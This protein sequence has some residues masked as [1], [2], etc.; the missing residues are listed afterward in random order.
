MILLVDNFDSFTFNLVDYFEQLGTSVHI[1]RNNVSPDAIDINKFKGIV[2]SPGPGH[3][4]KAGYLMAIIHKFQGSIPMLGIC[5]GHQAIGKYYGAEIIKAVEPMHGKIS[6]I[7]I[8]KD[9]IFRDMPDV[10]KVVRYHSLVLSTIPENLT[11]IAFTSKQE[12]M[13]IKHNKL[14]I[15]GVQFHPEAYLTSYGIKLLQNWLLMVD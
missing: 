13:A 8:K 2:L 14:P 10:I 9:P 1:I 6:S 5:L 7:E 15:Y 3:P 11:P 4:D 12:I